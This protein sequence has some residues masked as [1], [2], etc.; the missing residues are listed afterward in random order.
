MSEPASIERAL[1]L[2]RH[3]DLARAAA[4][5]AQILAVEPNR[6]DAWHLLGV[7]TYESGDAAVA[8]RHLRQAIALNDSRATAHHHLGLALMRQQRIEEAAAAFARAASLEPTAIEPRVKL[9][10]ARH[11]LG[12]LD[13]A[14][15]DYEQVLAIDAHHVDACWGLGCLQAT[16]GE[17]AS[18][19]VFL[20]MVVAQSPD[21]GEAHH[22]LGK[23][24]FDLGLMDE[25]VAVQR[26]AASLLPSE[27][28]SLRTL[29]V[30]IPGSPAADNHAVADARRAWVAR[31]APPEPLRTIPSTIARAGRPMRVGYLSAFFAQRNWMKPVWGLVN[32]H[33]RDRFEIHL[34]GDGPQP[35]LEHGYREDTRDR[36]HDLT[37]ASNAD[38]AR[39]IAQAGLDLLVDLNA[40]SCPARVPL[41]ASKPAPIL[42]AWFNHFAPSGIDAIDVVIGDRRVVPVSERDAWRER[43]V[44]VRGSYLIFDVTY[45]T[46]NVAPAPCASRECVTFGA[47]C[48]QYKITPAV[49][50]AWARILTGCPRSRLIIRNIVLGGASNRR[51]V[52]EQFASHGIAADRLELLGPAE[53]VAFLATYADV[54]LALDPFPYNGGTTTMEALWQG[55]P[56]LTFTGDR[57][58]SRIGASLMH[59][60]GLS[61][62]VA[63][64]LE[65]HVAMAIALAN[66]PQTP[67]RLD[68]LRRMMR[69]RL[70]RAP[71]CDVRRFARDMERVY[72]RAAAALSPG[73]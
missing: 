68:D 46:P 61:E 9:A 31:V 22:N 35:R 40:Y 34:F 48:P 27:D 52:V 49:V 18:A 23:S 16:R 37:G 47:L 58:A 56:V 11:L 39:V 30:I 1:E 36:F 28:L 67:A 8:E 24:L 53:H 26:R 71:V 25:A 20:T 72:R 55:V 29:A 60:A 43:V 41:L 66:D 45:P 65:D 42:V 3:G 63:A 33:D 70:R 4:L 19:A 14:K 64:S 51:F 59:N 6:A 7:A 17:H 2:H 69:E 73:E 32:H 54:D 38:A 5:Y 15:A 57:W 12:H 13:G 21:W 44:R 62:F 50:A 10:D